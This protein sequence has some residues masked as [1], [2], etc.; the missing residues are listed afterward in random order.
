MILT[1]RSIANS[2]KKLTNL[3]KEK[4]KLMEEKDND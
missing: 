2:L 3:N 4:N 1:N